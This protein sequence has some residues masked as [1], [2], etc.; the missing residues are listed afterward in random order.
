VL[1]F[2]LN[3][4]LVRLHLNYCVQFWALHYKKKHAVSGAC[5]GKFSEDV[6]DLELKSYEEQLREL[7]L[8]LEKDQRRPG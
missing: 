4:A 1:I 8:S 7:G 5:P 6:M 3:L 2:S